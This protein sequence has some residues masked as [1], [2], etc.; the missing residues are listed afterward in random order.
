MRPDRIVDRH[1][2]RTRRR[3]C[4]RALYAPFKR[5]HDRILVM[6]VRSAELTKYA[7]N[8]ML[9]TRI[10]V[11]ERAREPR[12]AGRRRHRAGAPRH[13]LGPAHRLR[14]SSIAGAGYGGSC[15]PKDV[16]ALSRTARASTATRCRCC[17]AVERGQRRAEARAVAEDRRG[18]SAQARAARTS[19]SGGSPSSR[20][21]TTCARRRAAW[22]SPSCWRAAR[23]SAC[24]TRWRSPGA[25]ACSRPTSP[26]SRGTRPAD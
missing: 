5:N 8:A 23:G 25:G 22:S 18:A 11:H 21:P 4:M 19:R 15:F 20:T 6:D 12:R 2:R 26:G 7:A 13:R 17:D 24:S 3:S 16:K 14:A 10:C 9:A 1:R